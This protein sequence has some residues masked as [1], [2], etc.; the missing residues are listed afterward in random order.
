MP[1]PSAATPKVKVALAFSGALFASKLRRQGAKDL[2]EGKGTVMN[3]P[4]GHFYRQS[5]L[6][7]EGVALTDYH[8]ES[9]NDFIGVKG[10]RLVRCRFRQ[11]FALQ[12]W[13]RGLSLPIK[14]RKRG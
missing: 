10:N 2:A 11:V 4:R 3:Y 6:P 8:P 7:L 1:V 14:G 12:F 5:R 13:Q 9:E